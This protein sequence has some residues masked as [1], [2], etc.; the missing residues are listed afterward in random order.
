MALNLLELAK[1][2]QEQG[3]LRR[4]IVEGKDETNE[5]S[6]LKAVISETMRVH[7]TVPVAGIKTLGKD[8]ITQH[9]DY[10]LPKGS[11]IFQTLIA[12]SRDPTIFEKPDEFQPSR[13]QNASEAA[14]RAF[15]PFALGKRNSAFGK[16]RIVLGTSPP[17]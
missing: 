9:G 7:P 2:P 16:R 11:I 10:H 6:Y 15:F 3:R 5:S 13:W 8:Y 12:I 14:K 4:E 1:H 17:Y